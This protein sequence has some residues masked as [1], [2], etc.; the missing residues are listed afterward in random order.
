MNVAFALTLRTQVESSLL[1]LLAPLHFC[2]LSDR[3]LE[4]SGKRNVQTFARLPLCT[5][6]NPQY[7]RLSLFRV[8]GLFLAK[9]T[10]INYNHIVI[11]FQHSSPHFFA[12]FTMNNFRFPL[13][14][15]LKHPNVACST[16]S[17]FSWTQGLT[18]RNIR[19]DLQ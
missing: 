8:R 7:E 9:L 17:H 6:Y 1:H 16:A 10:L 4:F 14:R 12:S 15:R 13:P 18:G 5:H 19:A 11:L 3:S 2:W